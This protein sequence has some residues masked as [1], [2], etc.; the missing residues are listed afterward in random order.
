MESLG[1]GEAD[2]CEVEV[3]VKLIKADSNTLKL[4]VKSSVCPL[5]VSYFELR[6][7]VLPSV[8]ETNVIL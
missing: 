5:L 1:E 4:T 7:R 2:I 6:T 3:P 8:A